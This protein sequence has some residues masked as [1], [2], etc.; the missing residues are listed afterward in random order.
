V[1]QAGT[2]PLPT[3]A[4]QEITD[5][6]REVFDREHSEH[7]DA[8]TLQ[9]ALASLLA[10]YPDAPIAAIRDDGVVVAMPSSIG[11]QRNPVLEAR[12]ALDLI[13]YDDEVL[14]GWDRVLTVGAAVYAVH[15]MSNP[16]ITGTVYGLDLRERHGVILTVSV[17]AETDDAGRPA[18]SIELPE[19]TPRFASVR[20]DARSFLSSVDVAMTQIL[21]WSAEEMEGHRSIEFIHPDDHALAIDNWMQ[22]LAAPGPARRVRLRHRRRDESWVWLE[23]TNHN[24]LHDP[25]H[26]CVVSEMV[27]ISEE[28]SAHEALKAREQLLDSLA[29]AVPVGLLQVNADR[30]VVYTNDRLHQILGVELTE[31]ASAQM[32]S[33][34]DDDRAALEEALDR[35][36]RDGQQSDM[37]VELRRPPSGELR[38]CTVS[39]RALKDA[40]GA[41]HGAIA[42]VADITDG[43][44]MREELERRAT[45]DELTGC[46]NRASIMRALEVNI[47]SGERHA[48]RAVV[49]VDLD[50]FKAVNDCYGHAAGDELLKAVAVRLRSAVRDGDIVGRIGG[51]EFL[52]VCPDVGG[53]EEAM[54]LAERLARAQSA[55]VGLTGGGVT[56]LV[57]IGV[58]WSAGGSADAYSIVARADDAMY[59][60]KREG[61]GR[62]KLASVDAPLRGHSLQVG[63]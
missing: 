41:I 20:K 1:T 50:G 59:A 9:R 29:E 7:L 5:L 27:D 48:E 22:M 57:S 23:V 15:P 49:F 58:A 43:A 53:P 34:G 10:A 24:L 25:D 33:V 21:G 31:D 47:A 37:E 46:Y 40:G 26:H 38:F 3:D 61:A 28:M 4:S 51:D 17:F 35:V 56:A 52:V 2:Q 30:R 63:V 42:C 62:P 55:A 6:V 13:V 45:F 18:P 44:R 14:S 16:E 36:L 8:E 54:K 60:S 32:A 19:V 11:L 12:S 39:L